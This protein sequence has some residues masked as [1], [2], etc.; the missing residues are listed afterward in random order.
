[1]CKEISETL[2]L[3][4]P[5]RS[6]TTIIGKYLASHE[7]CEYAFEPPILF[8]IV[9][10]L[11]TGK[12]SSKVFQELVDG[13]LYD[14]I[15]PETL[16]GRRINTNRWDDSSIYRIKSKEEINERLSKSWNK[17]DGGFQGK[18]KKA[19]IILKMPDIIYALNKIKTAGIANLI[20]ISTVRNPYANIISLMKKNWFSKEGLESGRI[21][22]TTKRET[23]IYLPTWALVTAEKFVAMTNIQ[24]C[25]LYIEIMYD[26]IRSLKDTDLIS[27]KLF[28]TNKDYRKSLSKRLRLREGSKTE[29]INSEIRKSEVLSQTTVETIKKE[30][31]EE[32]T[33]KMD[34][35]EVIVNRLDEM[36]N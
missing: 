11:S 28:T 25:A 8:H 2:L 5:A 34:A 12:I 6:G 4:G 13:Y 21:F 23:G 17:I 29:E 33:E 16:A 31:G 7:N 9:S 14:E 30:I 26:E 32:L 22:P 18:L 27:Y 19:K 10:G 35:I 1:M 15:L 24:R 20:I 36:Y 3:T